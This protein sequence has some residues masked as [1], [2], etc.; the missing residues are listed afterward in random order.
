M[1]MVVMVMVGVVVVVEMLVV[2]VLVGVVVVVVVVANRLDNFIGSFGCE[3]HPCP[4]QYSSHGYSGK[5]LL[6]I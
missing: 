2:M 4:E 1:V 3:R 6:F 5:F